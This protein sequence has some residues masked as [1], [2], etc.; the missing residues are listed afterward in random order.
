MRHSKPYWIQLIHRNHPNH[1]DGAE[2][3]VRHHGHQPKNEV[4]DEELRRRASKV[5]H[6][7]D[8]DVED[9]DLDKHKRHIHHRLRDGERRGAVEREGFREQGVEEKQEEQR[10]ATRESARG[11]V[12]EVEE[13][14][15][16]NEALEQEAAP[17]SEERRLVAEH[18]EEL[19]MRARCDLLE[20][21]DLVVLFLALLRLVGTTFFGES[22]QLTL[23]VVNVAEVLRRAWNTVLPA[24]TDAALVLVRHGG[25]EIGRGPSLGTI[26]AEVEEVLLRILRATVVQTLALVDKEDFVDEVVELLAGLVQGYRGGGVGHVGHCPDGPDVLDGRAGVKTFA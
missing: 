10:T 18:N 26:E 7:V 6:E 8:E 14:R 2:E 16:D 9:D 4:G 15:T 20:K 21:G 3:G 25:K 1:G 22:L 19:T 24:V 13:E 17:F 5:G 12:G 23:K 11:C